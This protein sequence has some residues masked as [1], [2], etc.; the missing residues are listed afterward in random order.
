VH[1]GAAFKKK[2]IDIVPSKKFN[3][4]DRWIPFNSN[5]LRL[6]LNNFLNVKF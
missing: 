1:V 4:L 2:I 5:Y 3:E 6:D